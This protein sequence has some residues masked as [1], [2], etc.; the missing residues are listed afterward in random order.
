M[1][2]TTRCVRQ[3]HLMQGR[4]R[5]MSSRS[6]RMRLAVLALGVS[7]T[8]TGATLNPLV[9]KRANARGAAPA[10]CRESIAPSSMPRVDVAEIPRVEYAALDLAPPPAGDLRTT[11]RDAQD[12][13]RRNDRPVFDATLERAR[14]LLAT[15][16]AGA[17]RRAADELV[18][19]YE[20][21]QQVWDAQ[22]E[23][24]FFESASP[25][26]ARLS[27]Y[28]G[29]N[30]AVRRARLT[31]D[32]DRVF[33][34][35]AESRTFLANVAADRLSRLG[36]R[37]TPVSPQRSR[38]TLRPRTEAP[39]SI[40]SAPSR[41]ATTTSRSTN[42]TSRSARTSTKTTSSPTAQSRKS[43]PA[44]PDPPARRTPRDTATPAPAAQQRPQQAST[45]P[46]AGGSSTTVPA[47][48]TPPPSAP[49]PAPTATATASPPPVTESAAT[50]SVA[51]DAASTASA[52]STD[53]TPASATDATPAVA[54]TAAT[55]STAAEPSTPAEER[56]RSILL[57]TILILIGLG[58]LIVLFR[59]SK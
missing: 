34:P 49:P 22:F 44:S 56:Q 18:R 15:Y 13:L 26:H 11:L 31:D 45:P 37:T 53:A 19:I 7:L 46:A 50:A 59:A 12:A 28:P 43:A 5:R 14:T 24:P 9:T 25:L 4:V 32:R 29:W 52:S 6:H 1:T 35:A 39:R 20:D 3:A 57:P 58:V 55:Q 17:E 51:T 38:A 48:V 33:Y 41:S 2:E 21:A 23:S 36:I 8:L 30:D 27:A 10:D 47:P 40:T 42:T 16:P 54:D